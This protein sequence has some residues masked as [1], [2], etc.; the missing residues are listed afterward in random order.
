M[1]RELVDKWV[2]FTLTQADIIPILRAYSKEFGNRKITEQEAFVMTQVLH[3]NWEMLVNKMM[4]DLGIKYDC[5]VAEI[6]DANGK[7]IARYYNKP[8]E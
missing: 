3:T 5:N 6:Y 7:F 4:R 1:V 8:S 2:N